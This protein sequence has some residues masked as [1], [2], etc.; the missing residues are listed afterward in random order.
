MV[1]KDKLVEKT[2]KIEGEFVTRQVRQASM[3]KLDLVKTRLNILINQN[4][5]NCKY[6][7]VKLKEHFVCAVKENCLISFDLSEAS[8]KSKT[9]YSVSTVTIEPNR[10]Y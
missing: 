6:I 9:W 2:Q 8:E 4:R 7:I 3:S 5:I 10:T 1:R